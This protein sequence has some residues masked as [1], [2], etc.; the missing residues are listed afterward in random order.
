LN[1]FIVP[2]KS[3][4]DVANPNSIFF[5]SLDNVCLFINYILSIDPLIGTD[6]VDIVSYVL[7]LNRVM[8]PSEPPRIKQSPSTNLIADI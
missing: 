4:S 1:L 5:N 2:N 6:A 8:E 7:R 3:P